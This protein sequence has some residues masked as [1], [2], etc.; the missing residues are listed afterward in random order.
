MER[1]TYRGEITPLELMTRCHGTVSLLNLNAGSAG[2]CF[3][4]TPT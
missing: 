4:H 3:R 1:I 2:R